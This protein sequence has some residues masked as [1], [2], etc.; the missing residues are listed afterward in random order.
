M[1][2][3]ENS[4]NIAQ[5]IDCGHGRIEERECFVTDKI[6][7]LGELKFLGM[8]SIVCISATRTIGDSV[9]NEK[10]YYIS[11]LPAEAKKLIKQPVNIGV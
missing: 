4:L 5:D 3:S 7:W 2:N 10:R 6:D 11:S 8:R 1:N 9:T